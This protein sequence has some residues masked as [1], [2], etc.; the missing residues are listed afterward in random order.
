MLT[1]SVAGVEEVS[2]AELEAV[3]REA[4]RL[5][6]R[7]L[8]HAQNSESVRRSA[9]A[10]VASVEHAF[11]ADEAAIATLAETGTTLVPTLVVTDV[12]RDLPGLTPAQRERQGEIERLHRRSCE[13]AIRLGVEV[14]TGTDT[15][16]R[17]VMPDMVW[18]EIALLHDHGASPMQ[19]IKAATSNAARL[20]GVDDEV[21]TIEAGRL[22]DLILVDGDPLQ[23]LSR[24]ARPNRVMQAGRFIPRP[25][26]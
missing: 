7:V 23:D 18:R 14:A 3:V 13:T 21:G 10:G 12:W 16:V 4:G 9:R 17:G 2:E 19:A 6:R 24:L 5:H 11:L 26:S 25:A 8:S 20:L 15:G 22:A 1:S